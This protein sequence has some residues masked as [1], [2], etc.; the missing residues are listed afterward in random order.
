MVMTVRAAL[1][2]EVFTRV[3]LEI[4]A[5]VE[6]LGRAI[7]WVHPTEIPDIAKF[8]S[9]GEM[10]LTAGLGIGSTAERQREYITQIADAGAAVL[11]IEL[12]GR[13]FDT[14]PDA[15]IEA[16][17][18]RGFPLV[19]LD[20]ELPFVEVSAQ[21]HE[22]IVDQRVL[23]LSAYERLNASFMQLLLAGGDPAL[24][25][26]ALSAEVDHPV[27]LEDA[28]RQVIAYSGGTPAGD[29]VLT[30]WEHH[31]RIDH[32][33]VTTDG[34]VNEAHNCTRRAVVLRGE[35]WGWLHVLHGGTAVVGTAAYAVDRATDGIAI[36][37]L[38]ARESGA[39][40][41]Q[42]QNALVS[43]LLLG[44]ITGDAFVGRALRIGRDLR[45]RALLAVF[46]CRENPAG[47]TS[48]EAIEELCRTL[49]VPAVV[50]D[51]GEHTLAIMGL[52]R[53]S[54]EKQ[55]VER[56]T[57]LN[58]RAGI[59]RPVSASQLSAAVEQARS[60]AS[61]A[62]ARPDKQVH[63]FDDL[64]VLRLLAS[65]AGGPELARYIEDELS[66]ILKHDA[67]ATNPLLPTLRTYLSCDGNK[68]QAAQALF[69]QR[70]TLYYRLE[71]ITSLLG[72]SLDDPDTRQALIFA[73]RGH[74]LLQRQ[75]QH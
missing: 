55:V 41:A 54:S 9:G 73:V 63:R 11:I 36:A 74:D 68:S 51:L 13:T 47:N 57:A 31:S 28:T 27:V 64:G 29:E 6:N 26:D 8:L 59:S 60:A 39:R 65:L 72:R 2:L 48:D 40:S 61:V 15:L 3:P 46:V 22:S 45:D 20:G 71:R 42:R 38:G 62:A 17:R 19:G 21:V 56:L 23:D 25:T 30:E 33:S 53:T 34:N 5:G 10:L 58:V 35:R 7:R 37:L 43:R 70:R 66:P 32:D 69:V 14:M 1:D 16:A 49:H 4:Y 44:D 52:S 12:S 75:D 18:G 67:K 24:F 50:A